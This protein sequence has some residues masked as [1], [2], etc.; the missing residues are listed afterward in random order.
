MV[1]PNYRW[2]N[3]PRKSILAT[4]RR[5]SSTGQPD[6]TKINARTKRLTGAHLIKATCLQSLSTSAGPPR[7]V[8][9][10]EDATCTC[11]H[12]NFSEFSEA[13]ARSL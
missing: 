7:D 13:F 3:S 12:Y 9:I 6:A 8:S 11:L 1:F 4:E 2:G 5:A 10:L